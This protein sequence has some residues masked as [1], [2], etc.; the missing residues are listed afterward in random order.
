MTFSSRRELHGLP[1]ITALTA[2]GAWTYPLPHTGPQLTVAVFAGLPRATISDAS[3]WMGTNDKTTMATHHTAIAATPTER[4]TD[5]SG[6]VPHRHDG[7]PASTL[8]TRR[9]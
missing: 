1:E 7:K 8:A 6:S 2:A 9:R 4:H 3:A 5:T